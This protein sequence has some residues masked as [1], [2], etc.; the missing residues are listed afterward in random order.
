MFGAFLF[1]SGLRK[2]GFSGC[3]WDAE[4]TGSNPVSATSG[5]SSLQSETGCKPLHV[6]LLPVSTTVV[7]RTLD[8]LV[9]VRFHHGQLAEVMKAVYI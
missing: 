2:S 9:V 7:R 1:Y 4:R 6:D 5:S 3:I 8:S